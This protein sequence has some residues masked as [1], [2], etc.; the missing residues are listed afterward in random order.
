MNGN[1]R[2]GLARAGAGLILLL[3]LAGCAVS[4]AQRERVDAWV[5]Q[6][7]VLLPPALDLPWMLPPLPAREAP[8]HQLIMVDRGDDALALRLHLIR[9]ATSSI[10]I[11]NYIFLLD[12]SGQLLLLELLA[13]AARGVQ[14]RILVDSLFSVPDENVQAALELAHPNF[15]L[16]VFRPV[17]EQSVLR[18]GEFIAAVFCCFHELNQRMHNKLMVIDDQHALIGGRNHSAR[19]FDLDPRMV[20]VDMETLVTGPV[21]AQMRSGFDAFWQHPLA[22]P[23]RHTRR[24]SNQIL[25]DPP[26]QIDLELSDRLQRLH[27]EFGQGQWLD[28]LLSGHSFEVGE[29]EYFTDLPEARPDNAPTP[30][31]DSTAWIHGLIARAEEEVVIQTP[32]VVLSDRFRDLLRALDPEVRVVISSNS[33]ASTDAFPVYAISRKQ[34]AFLLEALGIRF[35]EAMPFPDDL[36]KLV[37]RYQALVAERAAGV[38]TPMRGDPVS[39]TLDMPGPRLSLHAKLVVVD[40]SHVIVTSHNLDPR[41]EIYNTENGILVDDGDFAAAMLDY[42][43]VITRPGNSWLSAMHSSGHDDDTR[44]LGSAIHR[45]GSRLSRRLPVL[46]LWPG[47]RFEQF[48]LPDSDDDDETRLWSEPE[49]ELAEAEPVGLAP[50]VVLRQRR[51]VTAMVSRMM[52]FLRP[53]L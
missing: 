8:G 29:V 38:E 43:G 44:S 42:I 40:R 6:H 12:D 25:N 32:Y 41:S 45:G 51:L 37:P 21:A 22:M 18:D 39:A 50:E 16:R 47:Y 20:F 27:A 14:V 24:V 10:E 52:G 23:P 49:S 53:I 4:P 28:R 31:D 3:V 11:Q 48:R 7:P 9:T 13:A 36:E 19:Y 5:K 15:K 1:V 26:Q 34:R 2:A 33:L 30:S 35:F 46:D 17:L